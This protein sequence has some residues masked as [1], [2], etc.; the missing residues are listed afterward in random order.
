[1][2]LYKSAAQAIKRK[3]EIPLKM[4]GKAAN[5]LSYYVPAEL[6]IAGIGK[7]NS[8]LKTF[9]QEAKKYGYNDEEIKENLIEKQ[10]KYEENKPASLFEEMTE[11]RDIQSL[12]EDVQNQLA[13]LKMATEQLESKGKTRESPEL[14]KIAQ[15][16][17]QILSGK[18]SPIQAEAMA[19]G[20]QMQGQQQPQFNQPVQQP[21]AAQ[22]QPGQGMQ[23]L[24]QMIQE[25]RGKLGQ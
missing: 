11:G 20:G 21:Q 12:P 6:T 22:G 24:M 8:G 15:K 1:M 2:E 7:L 23:A 18:I 13:F 3:E 14:K 5:L 16:V 9:F 10:K 19:Q 17:K 25:I 4:M